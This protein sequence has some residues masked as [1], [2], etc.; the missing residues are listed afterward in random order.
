MLLDTTASAPLH[1]THSVTCAVVTHHTDAQ[2]RHV[3]KLLVEAYGAEEASRF[4][5][6][7]VEVYCGVAG[8]DSC[9]TQESQGLDANG[10]WVEKMA[11][12]VQLEYV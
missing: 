10:T 7:S 12:H 8:T 5:V 1:S 3:R 11:G 9:E 4:E 2:V 6:Q